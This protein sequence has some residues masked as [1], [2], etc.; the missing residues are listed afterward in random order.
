MA[1]LL[2]L[3]QEVIQDV[4]QPHLANSLSKAFE[5]SSTALQDIEQAFITLTQSHPKED[6]L[7]TFFHNWS[8]TNNSAASLSGYCNRLTKKW[9]NEQNEENGKEHLYLNVLGHLNRVSDEDLGVEGGTLH[10]DLYYHMA[11]TICGNDNWLSRRYLLPE[12]AQFKKW[13]DHQLLREK[14]LFLGLL[15]TLVHE[16]YTH[17]EVEFILPLFKRWLPEIS[18]LSKGAQTR[19]LSWI[20]VHTCGTERNHFNETLQSVDALS[21]LLSVNIHDYDLE[22]VFSNYLHQKA[23][24]MKA[25]SEVLNDKPI[26]NRPMVANA[27]EA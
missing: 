13:K 3:I 24:V 15:N 22:L 27:F 23:L 12:G 9:R 2:P 19:C 5:G 26:E 6:Q 7:N 10:F 4:K 18:D 21:D 20:A 16:I 14:D 1:S 8:M 17:G 25:L 11:T